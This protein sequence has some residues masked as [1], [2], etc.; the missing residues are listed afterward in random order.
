MPRPNREL[1]PARPWREPP[2]DEAPAILPT[3]EILASTPSV[4]IAFVGARAYSNGLELQLEMH[5]RRRDEDD[6]EWERIREAFFSRPGWLLSDA[7]RVQALTIA[8]SVDGGADV[9]A[10]ALAHARG[11]VDAEPSGWSLSLTRLGGSGGPSSLQSAPGLWLWRLP[12]SQYLDLI[13]RWP[14]LDITEG[15]AHVDISGIAD[16]SRQSQQL[17]P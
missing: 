1:Q 17:W 4:A 6:K 11:P 16:L 14:A 3:V 8:V 15:R 5:A 12:P 13:I 2:L 9:M 7:E 10:D